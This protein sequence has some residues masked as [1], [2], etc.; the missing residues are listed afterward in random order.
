MT[1]D[2]IRIFDWS[3]LGITLGTIADILPSVAALLSII[4]M[5]IRIYVALKELRTGSG[6]NK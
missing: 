5:S 6:K 4:W 1:Q 3:A 2:D